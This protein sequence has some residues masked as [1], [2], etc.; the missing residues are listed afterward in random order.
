MTKDIQLLKMDNNRRTFHQDI[1]DLSVSMFDEL[2]T[3]TYKLY[4]LTQGSLN[5]SPRALKVKICGL[6]SPFK[7]K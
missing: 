1:N 2:K 3:K 4:T 7:P 6:R 5:C